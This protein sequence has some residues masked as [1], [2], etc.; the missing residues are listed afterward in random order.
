MYPIGL[1][2][3]LFVLNII[4]ILPVVFS[5][6]KIKNRCFYWNTPCLLPGQERETDGG[7]V[8]MKKY[9]LDIDG[10]SKREQNRLVIRLSAFVK[11]PPST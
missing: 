1:L 10:H 4:Y 2:E 6:S 7:G 5:V 8:S 9:P 3:L 11:L